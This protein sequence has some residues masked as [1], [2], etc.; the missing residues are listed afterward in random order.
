VFYQTLDRAGTRAIP[1]PPYYTQLAD[2][3]NKFTSQA[4]TGGATPKQALDGMQRQLESIYSGN[5]Y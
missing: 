2:V 5:S 3:L 4:M 1:A